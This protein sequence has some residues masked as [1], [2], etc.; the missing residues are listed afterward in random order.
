MDHPRLLWCRVEATLVAGA[1]AVL[2]L[3]AS[4]VHAAAL[5]GGDAAAANSIPNLLEQIAPLTKAAISLPVAAILGAG[6]ACRPRSRGTPARTPAVIHT[7]IVLALV[8]AVVMLVVGSSLARAF[9]IVGA[10]GLVRYRAKIDDPKDAGVMLASL[11][12]GLASGVGL[13][14]LAVFAA[15]FTLF[16]LFAVESLGPD[17]YRLFELTVTAKKPAA[18]QAA[19]EGVLRRNRVQYELRS[20][21]DAEMCYLVKLPFDRSTD[22]IA[23]ALLKLDKEAALAVKWDEK[24]I[25]PPGT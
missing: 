14:L 4:R 17:A 24:K 13:Y 16:V 10:A 12:V 7:Q 21:S 19:I 11:A 20:A 6:L 22:R 2:I 23:A 5:E 15:L 8:G 25:K 18:L 9:G 1:G 3:W